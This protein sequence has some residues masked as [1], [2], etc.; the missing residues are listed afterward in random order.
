MCDPVDQ[1]Q[2]LYLIVDSYVRRFTDSAP[3]EPLIS[4]RFRVVDALIVL[5]IFVD[6]SILS[7]F[8]LLV[9]CSVQYVPKLGSPFHS[10]IL[11]QPLI[12]K[13]R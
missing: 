3:R 9:F 1:P 10:L 5:S 8:H 7:V 13:M 4:L 12:A 2:N 11:S 6:F